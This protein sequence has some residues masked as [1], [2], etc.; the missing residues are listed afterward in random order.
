[1][2]GALKDEDREH[3][4]LAGDVCLRRSEEDDGDP[5]GRHTAPMIAEGRLNIDVDIDE[6]TE[7]EDEGA[8]IVTTRSR[9]PD[10]RLGATRARAIAEETQH[11]SGFGSET[12]I[13]ASFGDNDEENKYFSDPSSDPCVKRLAALYRQKCQCQVNY[14][15]ASQER[16]YQIEAMQSNLEKIQCQKSPVGPAIDLLDSMIL[17]DRAR[18]FDIDRNALA[19]KEEAV[20][21]AL[22]QLRTTESRIA[23][24]E[25]RLRVAIGVDCEKDDDHAVFSGLG[26]VSP[27]S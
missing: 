26:N 23:N 12:S 21:I 17:E 18:L 15:Y 13:D 2:F 20:R 11:P 5:T 6:H 22:N 9:R 4:E 14:N 24:E 27:I 10:R 3:V 1:M 7:S 8:I 25:A 19:S 16:L